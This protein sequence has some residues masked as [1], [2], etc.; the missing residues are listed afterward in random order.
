VG[1]SSAEA[2]TFAKGVVGTVQLDAPAMFTGK[3]AGLVLGDVL[4][5]RGVLATKAT[6]TKGVLHVTESNGGPLTYDVAG[7]TTGN[8]FAI[9]SDGHGGSF[10]TLTAGAA[11][12][13]MLAELV[14]AALVGATPGQPAQVA[15]GSLPY[16][17]GVAVPT[18][19]HTS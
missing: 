10:L 2:V 14:P 1:S 19:L 16:V 6:V 5:L 18:L 15:G 13:A 11:A 9:T 7:A 12:A 3:I 4:D 17:P 8:H